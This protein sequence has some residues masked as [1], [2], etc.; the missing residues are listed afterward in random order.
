MTK[1]I[2]IAVALLSGALGFYA[3]KKTIKPVTVTQV[4]EIEKVVTKTVTKEKIVQKDGTT[5]ERE[6]VADKAEDKSKNGSVIVP[7]IVAQTQWRLGL[8]WHP[9]SYIPVDTTISRRL[10]G[11]LWL[12]AGANWMDARHPYLL[13]GVSYD[14]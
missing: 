13:I 10:L 3:A 12:D 5:I 2:I 6:T 9:T 11:N 14:F 1:Y 4:K 8:R 7:P